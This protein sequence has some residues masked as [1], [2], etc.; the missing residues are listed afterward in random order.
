MEKVDN[1]KDYSNNLEIEFSSTRKKEF[2]FIIQHLSTETCKIE[3]VID[4]IYS[5]FIKTEPFT[6][7]LNIPKDEL[8]SFI[9]EVLENSVLK[10]LGAIAYE[11]NSNSFAG[12]VLLE[13]LN[14]NIT[15]YPNSQSHL[16]E[17]LGKLNSDLNFKGTRLKKLLFKILATKPE[18]Q[19]IGL[20]TRIIKFI[21][22]EHLL[23]V[24]TDDF[25][26][27]SFNEM[28]HTA[29]SKNGFKT[30]KSKSICEE[31]CLNDLEENL[32][33]KN[34]CSPSE[35]KIFCFTKLKNEKTGFIKDSEYV[36]QL[37][38]NQSDYI[39][40]KND[41]Q[42]E[43]EKTNYGEAILVGELKKRDIINLFNQPCIIKELPSNKKGIWIVAI[44]IFTF[45]DVDIVVPH[46]ELIEKLFF[47]LENCEVK[48]IIESYAKI[49]YKG[50]E[51]LIEM[52]SS[53]KEE[54][55]FNSIKSQFSQGKTVQVEIIEILGK[56]KITK[57]NN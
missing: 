4:D 19:N 20:I 14:D 23:F 38:W 37:E 45:Q 3:K 39:Y 24:H 40:H 8:K 31:E 54:K 36:E 9:T 57:L 56:K 21:V 5:I 48:D 32:L 49:I 47:T 12:I 53:N 25:F 26:S 43:G 30:V 6:I 42:Y 29:F 17:S 28:G 15:P 44:N 33:S 13:D 2:K 35:Y 11:I 1:I 7:H 22:N 41:L 10:G 50:E 16:V 18:Y 55:L 27:F 51:I 46:H 34:L 52:P